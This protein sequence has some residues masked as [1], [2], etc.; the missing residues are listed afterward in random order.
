MLAWLAYLTVAVVWG[1]TYFAIALGL[2][3][4][5]PYGMVAARF[6]VAAVLALGLGRLRG[7]AWPPRREVVHLMVVGALLLGGSNALVSYAELHVSTGLVAVLA[8]L[9][10]LW[11]AVFSMAKAPLGPKGW[12]GIALGIAGVAVLVWPSGG[13]RIHPGGLA[14]M[15]AA[16]LIWAWGTLHGK[17][18]VHG[19]G[20][21]TN[22]GIQM[23]T[24]ALIGL[25]VAPLSGG[26]L[27][28]ALT[29]KALWAVGYLALFGSL[30]AFSA[31]IYLAKAWPPAKMGT[32]AYLNPLV[33]VLLGSLILHEAFGLREILG[34]TIILAAVALVQLRQTPTT[35]K[36]PSES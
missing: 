6:S 36:L 22:V 7:E 8:A 20:L 30:L 13:L 31:Y 32:Y 35:G 17:H 19:G 27:R 10:P 14:A 26:F 23:L 3:S 25:A 28:G 9:V 16:P 2:A 11:L 33:A 29:A 24:A 18:F 4:F 15:V 12:A 1:S 21:M 34:M 5:T